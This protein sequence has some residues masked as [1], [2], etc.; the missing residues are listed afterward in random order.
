MSTD[1]VSMAFPAEEYAVAAAAC[2]VLHNVFYQTPTAEYLSEI[3]H[4]GLLAGWPDYG[5]DH[6]EAVAR[7]EQSL[8]EDSPADIERDYYQ[9]FIG[10]GGMTAYPWGSVYTDEE[11]LVCGET[12]RE[13]KHFCE[14]R[15]VRFEL[16]HSEPEDHI[17][18]VAAAL[19][20]FFDQAATTGSSRDVAQLLAD[21]VL[22][23]SHRVLDNSGEHAQTGYYLG[24]AQLYANLLEHWQQSLGITP[25]ELKLYA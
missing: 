6:A 11:N 13:F 1:T 25:R 5:A 24:F 14:T 20:R 8:A 12:T 4:S 17:G 23:W 18:L 21:H 7:I 16:E 22:P 15:G 9:L 3:R 19:S 10:P 2:G